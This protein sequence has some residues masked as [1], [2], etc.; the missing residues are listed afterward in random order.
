M[1]N[2]KWD[3]MGDLQWTEWNTIQ[4]LTFVRDDGTTAS[5]TP[6]HFRNTYRVSAGTNYRYTDQW[7]FR[8]G[9][10]WD[11][12]PV[13]NQYRTPRLP[14]TD[15]FWLAGGVRYKPTAALSLDVGVAYL[16]M[17]DGSIF[18][19]GNPPNVQANGL[20]DGNYK[21]NVWIVSGQVTYSF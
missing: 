20:I 13:K 21:N 10:A 6:E 4:D 15:R 16:F 12:T 19:S 7:M 2:D 17:Q 18:Q 8:G 3:F 14:D 11:Q 1:L 9:I 5:S